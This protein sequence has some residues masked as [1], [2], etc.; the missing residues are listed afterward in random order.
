M[1]KWNEL[2][3]IGTGYRAGE[4]DFNVADWDQGDDL[5]LVVM[6]SI[7]KG[8]AYII[9]SVYFPASNR[10]IIPGI[11]NSLSISLIKA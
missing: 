4:K 11:E 5:E 6:T 3:S 1:V 7:D 9:V 2:S 10:M 8:F